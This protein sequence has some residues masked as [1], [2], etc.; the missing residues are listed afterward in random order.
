[1]PS[2]KLI[3]EKS[4]S[5]KEAFSLPALKNEN[6]AAENFSAAYLRKT[7]PALPEVTELE[8]VRHFTGLSRRN[9]GIDLGFYPLGSCTMKYNPKINE[10]VASLAGFTE[11][12]PLQPET[13]VQGILELMY[14]FEK[15]L[16]SIFGYDC[17]TLAPFAGAHGELTAILIIRAYHHHRGD[18]KR[19]KIIVPD[20]SHGTNPSS[21]ALGGFEVVTVP[22][23]EKGMVSLTHLKEKLNDEVAGLMLTNPNTLGIFEKIFWK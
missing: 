11:L 13:S 15:Y 1:M 23:D 5:G 20:S 16:C 9:F 3:F 10:V 21:S 22:S 4:V 2:E 7:A 12:H 6:I 8:L 14:N 19:K 18:F 17:F